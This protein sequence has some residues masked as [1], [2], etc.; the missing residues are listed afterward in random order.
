MFRA[1]MNASYASSGEYTDSYVRQKELHAETEI[2]NDYVDQ[3]HIIS[4]DFISGC[5][6]DQQ[7]IMSSTSIDIR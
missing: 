7:I 2:Q 1:S 3:Q 5:T 6:S 4:S